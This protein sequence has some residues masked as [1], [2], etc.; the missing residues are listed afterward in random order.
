MIPDISNA[1]ILF[2]GGLSFLIALVQIIQ[3]RGRFRN[4]LL[5]VIFTSLA[6][7]QVQGYVVTSTHVERSGIG[8]MVLLL[9]EYIFGPSIYI[10]YLSLFQKDYLFSKKEF[11]HFVTS[12]FVL[13]VVIIVLLPSEYRTGFMAVPYSFI[14]GPYFSNKREWG[15]GAKNLLFLNFGPCTPTVMR[16]LTKNM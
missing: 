5:F 2:G 1:F 10:F 9:A 6:I 14:R 4:L 13:I 16:V 3:N 12:G 15:R 8:M 11:I 7:I